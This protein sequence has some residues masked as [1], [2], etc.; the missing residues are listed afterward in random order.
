MAGRT[1]I[2]G[3]IH[4]CYAELVALLD[5]LDLRPDDRVVAVGDL[6]VK[7]EQSREVLELFISEAHFSSVIG[8]HDLALLRYWR[9]ETVTLKPAQERAR[10]ELD[11]D[12]TRYAAYL[13]ALPAMI[14]LGAYLV[15]HAGVRPGVPLG[16]QAI[17]DLTA[18]RTLGADPQSRTGLPWYA[19]YNGPQT[20]LYGHW[21]AAAPRRASYAIG[22]DTGC[23]Y[24]FQLTAYIIETGEFVQVQARRAYEQ[25]KAR[26]A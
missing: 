17:E 5:R 19:L 18:L 21:P 26:V 15:V 23:V 22:L 11:A 7:G 8:N 12:K 6:I 3:D 20:I 9:G 13:S 4:G 1:I 24:G 14:D 16:A 25:P 10:Q 2:V